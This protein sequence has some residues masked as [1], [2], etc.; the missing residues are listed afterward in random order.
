MTPASSRAANRLQVFEFLR[1]RSSVQ[2]IH[3]ICLRD[4]SVV[5]S[6]PTSPITKSVSQI[7]AGKWS[8]SPARQPA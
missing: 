2:T 7:L 6:V 4:D 1:G 3:E 5:W 8:A